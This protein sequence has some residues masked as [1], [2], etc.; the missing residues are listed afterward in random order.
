MPEA[1]LTT[2]RVE[3]RDDR[4]V[5]TLSRPEARNAINTAVVRELD[6]FLSGGRA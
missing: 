2:L 5:V 1:V 3:E 4:V 6:A